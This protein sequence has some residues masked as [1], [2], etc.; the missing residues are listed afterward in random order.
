MQLNS[1]STSSKKTIWNALVIS[2]WRNIEDPQHQNSIVRTYRF[3]HFFQ[4]EGNKEYSNLLSKIWTDIF[5]ETIDYVPKSWNS[6]SERLYEYFFSIKWFEVYDF[7]EFILENIDKS[8]ADRLASNLNKIFSDENIPFSIINA[9]VTDITNPVENSE[10]NEALESPFNS[11]N[12]H[13]STSIGFLYGSKPDYR[14]SI[15]ESISAVESV[16]KKIT[17]NSKGT[18]GDLLKLLEKESPKHPAFREA[19]SRLYGYTNDSSGIRHALMEESNLTKEDAK[20]MLVQCS[21]FVN[22]I[23]QRSQK[24]KIT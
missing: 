20:L 13:I 11:S 6:F 19:L 4:Y 2:I 23:I 18:L 21:A 1:L 5:E 7:L 10:V 3:P 16:V 24:L 14:N 8:I 17:G 12:V 15:K 9:Q 22:Y